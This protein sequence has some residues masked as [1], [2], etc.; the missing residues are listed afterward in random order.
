MMREGRMRS[1]SLTSRRSGTSPV[2]SRLGWRHCIEATSR[3]GIFSSKTS[4]H[5]TTR[6]REGIAE[7]RQLSM[8][9]FP[10]LR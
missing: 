3:N 10:T 1:A 6:S 2:P 8:V 7:D 4:S 9:V 5:V